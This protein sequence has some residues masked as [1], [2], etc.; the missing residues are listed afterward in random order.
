[1][2]FR[3]GFPRCLRPVYQQG[4]QLLCHIYFRIHQLKIEV[5]RKPILPSLYLYLYLSL[6]F[7]FSIFLYLSLSF[8]LFLSPFLSLSFPSSLF[9]SNMHS[10]PLLIS[11]SLLL[12]LP[13]GLPIHSSILPSLHPVFFVL[14]L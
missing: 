2:L 13:R 7:S 4:S 12:L 6:F 9:P 5:L 3:S 10:L 1:M 14:F 11:L 8:Y